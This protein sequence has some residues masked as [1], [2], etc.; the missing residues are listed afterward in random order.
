VPEREPARQGPALAGRRRKPRFV[1]FGF[2]RYFRP[3]TVYN[4]VVLSS[5]CI[6]THCAGMLFPST[7]GL[8]ATG[9]G[10]LPYALA[11]TT[12]LKK[13]LT[14]APGLDA[15]EERWQSPRIRGPNWCSVV[16]GLDLLFL[17]VFIG[18]YLRSSAVEM[19]GYGLG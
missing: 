3:K 6:L 18:V 17:T 11:V 2:F 19:H 7:A 15:D 10:G 13:N 14:A 5:L 12:R 4:H 16:A 9:I 1:I 8:P